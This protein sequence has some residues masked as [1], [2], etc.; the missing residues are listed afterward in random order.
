[1]NRVMMYTPGD[2][3]GV[4][5]STG[6]AHVYTVGEDGT[7]TDENGHKLERIPSLSSSSEDSHRWGTSHD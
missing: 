2:Q 6:E 1:M 3:F 7:L 5:S 4:M